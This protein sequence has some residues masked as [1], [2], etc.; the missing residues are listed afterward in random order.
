MS[1]LPIRAR[2]TAAFALAMAV[3]LAGSG[4][5]LYARLDSHLALALDRDLQLRA[6]DLATLVRQPGASLAG[7]SSGRFIERGESYAQLVDPHGRVVDATRPLGP[8]RLLG[9]AELRAARQGP[10]YTNRN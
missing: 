1:R 3:V 10:I 9:T 2:V 8:A 7:D 6:Q 4:W 5:F